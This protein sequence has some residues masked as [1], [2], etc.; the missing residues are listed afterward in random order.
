MQFKLATLT[1]MAALMLAAT[2]GAQQAPPPGVPPQCQ[3]GMFAATKCATNPPLPTA[4]P[5]PTQTVYTPSVPA[6]VGPPVTHMNVAPP[7]H[8]DAQPSAPTYTPSTPYV[9]SRPAPAA[10][11]CYE[12]AGQVT[13]TLAD[14]IKAH[15]A[16]KAAKRSYQK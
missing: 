5:T 11:P 10:P 6:P 7:T 2:A 16:A 13:R 4:P 12:C 15:R 3:S 8:E 9:A 14:K 1:L